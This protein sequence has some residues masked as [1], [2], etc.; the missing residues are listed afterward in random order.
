MPLTQSRSP[1]FAPLRAGTGPVALPIA[2][3]PRT[4]AGP[5]TVSPPSSG[6]P[7]AASAAPEPFGEGAVPCVVAEREAE[8]RAERPGALGGEVGEIHRDQLPGDVAGRVVRQ[9]VDALD[10]HVVGE[11]ERLAADLQHRRIVHQPARR[12]IGGKAAHRGDEGGFVYRRS[13]FASASSRPL[14]KP[15]SRAS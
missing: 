1:A 15:V 7:K 14:T 2:V 4:R 8:Q 10:E 3:R 11:D 9:I 13:S 12:R 5:E 6:R